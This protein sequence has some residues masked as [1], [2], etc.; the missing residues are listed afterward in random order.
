[1]KMTYLKIAKWILFILASAVTGYF[2]RV[3]LLL[4]QVVVLK[5]FLAPLVASL[6]CWIV[7]LILFLYVNHA[8][9]DVPESI[10][11][12]IVKTALYTIIHIL[13]FAV[14]AGSFVLNLG[15]PPA[16]T[17]FS[18]REDH[19]FGKPVKFT[20]D[21]YQP[22]AYKTPDFN[23]A[24][25]YDPNYDPEKDELLQFMDALQDKIYNSDTHN[26][27][28]GGSFALGTGKEDME[29]QAA[30]GQSKKILEG[31]TFGI[32]GPDNAERERAKNYFKDNGFVPN[33]LNSTTEVSAYVK[34]KFACLY[35]DKNLPFD[36]FQF[37]CAIVE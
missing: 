2:F 36:D 1:M 11:G 26:G 20:P 15:I 7:W 30:P 25:A 24:F 8:R 29:W 18:G 16:H 13:V 10:G 31:R 35:Q 37:K 4:P 12:K 19:Y 28:E 22:V 17:D 33:S 21:M 14:A 6:I 9:E 3:W 32:K 23:G 27:K 5:S 34:G